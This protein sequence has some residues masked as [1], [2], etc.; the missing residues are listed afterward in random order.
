[1]WVV[2]ALVVSGCAAPH[3]EPDCLGVPELRTPPGR[4]VTMDGG[5]AAILTR[6]GVGDRI[7]GTAAPTFFEDFEG[8]ERARLDAIPV[9]DD[10]PGNAEKIIEARPDLVVGISALSFG[11]FDGTP[12]VERLAQAGAQSLVACDAVESGPVHDLRATM[13]FIRRAAEVFRIPDRGEQLIAELTRDIR[14]VT[15]PERPV[16]VLAL[17]S[18]PSPGE[19]LYTVGSRSMANGVISLAGG[20]NIADDGAGQFADI[21]IEQAVWRDPKVIVVISGI[22]HTSVPELLRAIRANRALA[23][24]TAVRRDRFVVV[25]QGATLSPSVLGG[26]AVATIAAVLR[27]A[28]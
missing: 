7:V 5:A 21:S 1:M 10:G 27:A 16:P 24:T 25:S 11:G 22:G 14:A 19:P 3:G 26:R 2:A 6:L 8:P 9:L 23:T 4:V 18:P 28:S 17:S 13:T 20:Q 12:T 15:P